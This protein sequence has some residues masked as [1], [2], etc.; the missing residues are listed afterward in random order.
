MLG[1]AY[2]TKPNSETDL[3]YCQDQNGIFRGLPCGDYVLHIPSS[4]DLHSRD[5]LFVDAVNYTGRQIPF[6]ISDNSPP[7]IDLGTIRL[8]PAAK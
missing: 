3:K 8:D 1:G 6:R 4:A 7:L 5:K 2:L